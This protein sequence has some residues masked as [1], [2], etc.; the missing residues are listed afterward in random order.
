VFTRGK[1]C[2]SSGR[3]ILGE[4]LES[5]TIQA[6]LSNSL[7]LT[8]LT[9]GLLV[10]IVL[11]IPGIADNDLPGDEVGFPDSPGGTAG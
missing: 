9:V 2:A 6:F 11:A 3:M 8:G 4:M 1:A 7:V 10:A 5:R